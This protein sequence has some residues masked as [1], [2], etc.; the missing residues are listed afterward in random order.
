M[1]YTIT[2]DSLN[3]SGTDG[4]KTYDSLRKAE[5]DFSEISNFLEYSD[6]P[7]KPVTEIKKNQTKL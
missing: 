1:S 5:N 6:K 3:G 7:T 2:I 4:N